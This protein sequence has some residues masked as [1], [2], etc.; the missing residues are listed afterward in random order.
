MK[1]VI[2]IKF[3]NNKIIS[4]DGSLMRNETLKLDDHSHIKIININYFMKK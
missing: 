3:L 4:E 1:L 2:Y